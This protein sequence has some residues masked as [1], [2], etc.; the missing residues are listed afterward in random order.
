MKIKSLNFL[1]V[2]FLGSV[3][4]VSC[5][6]TVHIEKDETVNFGNYKTYTWVHGDNS[7]LNNQSDLVE[8]RVR[9]AVNAELEKAGWRQSKNKPD[10]LLDYDL[11]VERNSR[12]KSEPVYSQPFSRLVYNPYTRRYSTIYYPSEFLGY[13]SHS[14][15]IKEGTITITMI[16]AKTDKMIWQGW[17]TEVVNSRN[18][19]G[20]EVQKA[21]ASIFKK[22]DLVIR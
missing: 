2:I 14:Q 18:L 16:D 15:T 5:A 6:S 13:E 1:A 9:Q 7:K 17:T 3:L 22:S 21:V 11:F 19:S 4:L 10:A 12:E 8:A 20:K